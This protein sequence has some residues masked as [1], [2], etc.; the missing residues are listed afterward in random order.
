MSRFNRR[1]FQAGFAGA[2]LAARNANANPA[3]RP[4]IA[5]LGTDVYQHS[6]AQHFLDRFSMGYAMGGKW[7]LPEVEIA[8]VYL[9]Q[10]N[11]RDIGKERIKK[12]LYTNARN[13]AKTR[14]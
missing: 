2:L 5:F 8:S 12:Y 7:H 9:D 4:K 3:A 6:H 10:F 1:T 13:E 11:E 14:G